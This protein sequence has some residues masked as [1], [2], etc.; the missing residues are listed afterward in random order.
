MCI[1]D[2]YD[3]LDKKRKDSGEV[4]HFQA[5]ATA[6]SGTVGNGIIDGV[7][8]QLPLVVQVLLFG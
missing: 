3:G 1:R 2:R 5:L 8:M 7:D 6:V 4:S